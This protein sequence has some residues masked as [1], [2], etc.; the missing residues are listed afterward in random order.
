[1]CNSSAIRH[2]VCI[3]RSRNGLSGG[4]FLHRAPRLRAAV[5]LHHCQCSC[6]VYVPQT[7]YLHHIQLM[8]IPGSNSTESE[9]RQSSTYFYLDHL[10]IKV[11]I[12]C[13]LLKC[14]VIPLSTVPKTPLAWGMTNYAVSQRFPAP[15][16]P[17]SQQEKPQGFQ[18]HQTCPPPWL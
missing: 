15:L 3:Y 9:N 18:I 7:L 12:I 1:M 2:C 4:V 14:C 8:S 17:Y 11:H 5:S 10:P 6:I 16:A 13:T